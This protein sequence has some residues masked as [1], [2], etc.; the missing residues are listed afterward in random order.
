MLE[1][2]DLRTQLAQLTLP[3]KC[4]FGERDQLVPITLAENLSSLN[5][6]I[7]IDRIAG[8]GHAPFISRP[9]LCADKISG[10]LHD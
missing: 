5:S 3:V 9:Q 7:S 10:F 1:T 8:A 4:I 6:T 2:L